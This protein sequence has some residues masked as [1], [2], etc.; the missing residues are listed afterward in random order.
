MKSIIFAKRNIKEIMRDPLSWFFCIGFPIIM[1][2]IFQVINFALPEEGTGMFNLVFLVP[3]ICVF[4]FSFVMLYLTIIVSKDKNSLFLIRLFAS[5]M[6]TIDYFLGYFIPALILGLIQIILCITTGYIIGLISGIGMFITIGE[7][8]LLIVIN[9]PILIFFIS[10]GILLG[11]L[12]SD[13]SA[14]GVCSVFISLAGFLSG[15]WMPMETMKSFETFCMFLPFYPAT[16]FARS[17]IGTIPISF[18]NTYLPLIIV[19]LYAAVFTVLAIF[20]FKR[21]M[22]KDK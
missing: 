18:Q 3:G 14:P 1:L 19:F 17:L 12:F 6:K 7:A 8:F 21:Y 10:V 16:K 2:I 22:K 20:V 15:A 9:L 4:S 13:K 11:T 5:P